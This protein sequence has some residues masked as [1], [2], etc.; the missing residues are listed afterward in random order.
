M[1]SCNLD[2]LN[3]GIWGFTNAACVVVGF[4]VH[5]PQ[6]SDLRKEPYLRNW[7]DSLDWV[8]RPA[9]TADGTFRWPR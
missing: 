9:P 1:Q 7:P 5:L 8:G 4:D 3:P 6:L 2:F